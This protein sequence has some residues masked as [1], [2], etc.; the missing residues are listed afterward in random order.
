MMVTK[1]SLTQ[2]RQE[3]VNDSLLSGY[4]N[5]LLRF[6]S[7][8]QKMFPAMSSHELSLSLHSESVI[9]QCWATPGRERPG[10][11]WQ[12]QESSPICTV[13]AHPLSS[14]DCYVRS[15]HD[16][17]P[18]PHGSEARK[19]MY[20]RCQLVLQS[21][22]GSQSLYEK[23]RHPCREAWHGQGTCTRGW[24]GLPGFQW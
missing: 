6:Y 10:A 22:T 23:V 4:V 1:A 2:N 21:V 7:T 20:W 16:V 12:F 3:N 8:H 24:G 15:S 11:H 13:S 5:L 17:I 19:D 14:M 9:C 18:A